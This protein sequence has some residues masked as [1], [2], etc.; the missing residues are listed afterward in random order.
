[1]KIYKLD[2]STC[3]EELFTKIGSSSAGVKILKD[4]AN[5]NL[6]YI[7]DIK[8]PG[9]NIL[10]QDALSI[11]ADLAVNHNTVTCKDKFSDAILIANDK[12]MKILSKKEF[13]QP[14][15]LKN[16]ADELKE[17]LPQK[18]KKVKVMGVLNVNEDSFFK[19]SRFSGEEA[20]LHVEKMIKEGASIIDLGGVSS[21]PGSIGVSDKEE[22]SRIKPIID[23]IH[24]AKLYEKVT[25]SIDSYSPL[26]IEYALKHGFSV[27]N[28]ITALKYDGVAKLVAKH[29]ATVVLMHKLGSTKNM[30]KNPEYEN[31]I[32]EVDEFFKN[33]IEKAK[34]FGIKNIVLDVGVGFGKSLE[35]NLTLIKHHA[36]FLHFGHELL[37]GASRKSMINTISKSSVDDRLSGTLALHLK[38]VQEGASIVRV[39]DVK[40][41][42]QAFRVFEAIRKVII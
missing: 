31:I 7:K 19:K 17:F 18:S 33:R 2:S 5:L 35:H 25:F 20:F 3:K 4:K 1:M 24:D 13:A 12:Q 36:H 30:Q 41:H 29:D 42:I 26:C 32:L 37:I 15:G 39:H 34:N 6:I 9:A 10:K 22:L 14:F 16:F 27:V 11:G 28:D 8:T 38:A 23:M 40:E 21:R